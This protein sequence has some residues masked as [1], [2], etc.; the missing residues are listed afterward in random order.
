MFA[1]LDDFLIISE[2]MYDC[3]RDLLLLV[4]TLRQLG[5]NINY[6][7]IEGPAQRITF[8]GITID[9]RDLTLTMPEQKQFEF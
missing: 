2:T 1:Y 6:S 3:S 4:R 9:T 7:K 5:F 8:L